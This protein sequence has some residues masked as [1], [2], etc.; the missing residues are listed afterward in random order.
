MS[1]GDYL[2]AAQTGSGKTLAYLLPVIHALKA[3]EGEEGM[4]RRGKRPKVLVLVPTKELV[5]QVNLLTHNFVRL[6]A[7]IREVLLHGSRT[8]FLQLHLDWG[9][10]SSHRQLLTS[11]LWCGS[12]KVVGTVQQSSHS[13][14]G[15]NS[16]L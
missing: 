10:D 12:V 2:L 9:K 14:N 15:L 16:F 1:G 13:C 11:R 5:E 3:R 8:S 6:G 4:E 7:C